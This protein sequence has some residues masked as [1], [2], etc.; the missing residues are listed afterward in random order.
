MPPGGM[1]DCPLIKVQLFHPLT[2]RVPEG[3]VKS[4]AAIAPSSQPPKIF[5]LLY[6][7]NNLFRLIQI[8]PH[9]ICVLQTLLNAFYLH[10]CNIVNPLKL[11]KTMS[12]QKLSL[13]RPASQRGLIISTPALCNFKAA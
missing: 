7:L 10:C 4:S 11:A 2:T 5:F 9:F 8:M 1:P 12:K 13:L 3:Q 6:H